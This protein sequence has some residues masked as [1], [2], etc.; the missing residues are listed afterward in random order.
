MTTL[1]GTPQCQ[2]LVR[3]HSGGDPVGEPYVNI[4]LFI[5]GLLGP[6]FLEADLGG[7][8]AFPTWDSLNL[9]PVLSY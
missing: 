3:A 5:G 9:E 2:S 8:L 7:P 1:A 4:N 6:S